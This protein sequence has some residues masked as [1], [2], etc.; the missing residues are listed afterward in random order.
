MLVY[1]VLL[2]AKSTMLGQSEVF[3]HFLS[4]KV[5]FTVR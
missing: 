2:A 1:W 5:L 3:G 4:S